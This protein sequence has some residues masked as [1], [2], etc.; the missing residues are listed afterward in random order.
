MPIQVLNML[1]EKFQEIVNEPGLLFSGGFLLLAFFFNKSTPP[2]PP[3]APKYQL[4]E[5]DGGWH[6]LGE[7][8][9]SDVPEAGVVFKLAMASVTELSPIVVE[10]ISSLESYLLLS[11][12]QIIRYTIYHLRHYHLY[13]SPN[14][15][16]YFLGAVDNL[17][18]TFSGE[19]KQWLKVC[20]TTK[21]NK[22]VVR[23]VAA[24]CEALCDDFFPQ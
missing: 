4:S 16:H 8:L 9:L 18:Y 12:N 2:P 15:M 17:N 13:V 22:A 14:R 1:A 21:D 19:I 6:K 10:A 11:D 7:E 24:S 20:E 23:R 3:P 5:V